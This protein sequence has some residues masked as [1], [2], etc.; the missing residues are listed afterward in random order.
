MLWYLFAWWIVMQTLFIRTILVCIVCDYDCVISWGIALR[1]YEF[2]YS[3]VDVMVGCDQLIN[4]L[5]NSDYSIGD[6]VLGGCYYII[7]AVL[8]MW[9]LIH[10]RNSMSWIGMVYFNKIYSLEVVLY[11][12]LCIVMYYCIDRG[13]LDYYSSIECLMMAISYLSCGRVESVGLIYGVIDHI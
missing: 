2:M 3:C 11:Q 13:L 9:S 4:R 1:L 10:H 8:F 5:H 12:C 6:Q 7:M